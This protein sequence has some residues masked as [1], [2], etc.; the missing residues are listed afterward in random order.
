VEK[1]FSVVFMGTPEFAVP[2]LNALVDYGCHIPLVVTRPDRAAGR[3]RNLIPPPVKTAA[4]SLGLSVVQPEAVNTN[5]FYEA[6]QRIHPDLL[7]VV[8]FGRILSESLLSMPRLGAINLHASLLPRYRGPAPIQWAIINGDPQT[9]V[10]AMRMDKGLDTG[11]I[12][13]R[14]PVPIHAEDTG[15]TLKKRLSEVSAGLLKKTLKQMETGTLKPIPQAHADATYAPLLKKKDGHINWSQPAV[16]IEPFIRGMIPWPGAYTFYEDKRIK[17][18][19]AAVKPEYG[20]APPGQVVAGF[21]D[22]LRVATGKGVLS[23]MEVQGAS[24]KRLQISDFLRGN[25]IPVGA[26]L[27]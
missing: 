25:P 21:S 14:E 12:L 22:E 10:T 9:G 5:H 11:D 13:M 17:I 4:V 15:K 24:G 7:V 19:K 27:A 16:K 8:A 20:D 23:V 26:R 18:F 3:G 1:R 2:A 6:M